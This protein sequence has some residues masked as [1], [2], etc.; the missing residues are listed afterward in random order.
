MTLMSGRSA[1]HVRHLAA[2]LRR[3]LM[4]RRAFLRRTL[5]MA[6]FGIGGALTQ[7]VKGFRYIPEDSMRLHTVHLGA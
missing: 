6:G 4:S 3:D 5:G 1:D 2:A 7:K